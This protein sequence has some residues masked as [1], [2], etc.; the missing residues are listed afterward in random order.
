MTTVDSAARSVFTAADARLELTWPADQSGVVV[1]V[2][3]AV[4]WI[5][6]RTPDV[7]ATAVASWPRV[8]AVTVVTPGADPA[9]VGLAAAYAS[10]LAKL[11][12]PRPELGGVFITAAEPPT[13]PRG[14][15]RLPHLVTVAAPDPVDEMVWEL[16]P[17]GR[18][19]R[20]IGRGLPRRCFVESRRDALVRLRRAL[21][22]GNLASMPAVRALAEALAGRDL[23]TPF[24]YEHQALV[25][26]A[27]RELTDADGE[28]APDR[29][30]VHP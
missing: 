4:R 13:P 2:D 24:V 20:L 27:L 7:E 29:G 5:A 3:A 15:V 10:Y 22:R 16:L 28:P 9:R 8:S 6:A 30:A 25:T 1:V 12:S 21:R 23:S 11:R 19:W 14:W 17:S 18:A 26:R